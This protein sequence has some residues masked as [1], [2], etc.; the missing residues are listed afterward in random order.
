[1]TREEV[2]AWVK[3]NAVEE[4]YNEAIS[5]RYTGE[6]CGGNAPS[7]MRFATKAWCVKYI[8]E[9]LKGEG[10]EVEVGEIIE[11]KKEGHKP[12]AKRGALIEFDGKAMNICAWG[13]ELGISPN[14]LYGRLYKMGWTV[15]KAFTTPG[16]KRK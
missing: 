9:L 1:M 12:T 2:D 14:T 3:E 6:S 7:E 4:I 13:E 15:E 16:K 5:T 10:Y 8:V 11:E